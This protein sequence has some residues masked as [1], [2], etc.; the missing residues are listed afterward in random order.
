[1]PYIPL[2]IA[3]KSFWL[4]LSSLTFALLGKFSVLDNFSK[5]SLPK[6]S[7]FG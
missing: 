1:M 5:F 7:R 2:V 4:K 6:V 3:L